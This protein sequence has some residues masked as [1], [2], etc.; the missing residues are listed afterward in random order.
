MH[1]CPECNAV[2]C[3]EFAMKDEAPKWKCN[4]CGASGWL[5]GSFTDRAPA[6][7]VTPPPQVHKNPGRLW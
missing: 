7:P 4:G 1:P 6:S 5:S 3:A 2:P